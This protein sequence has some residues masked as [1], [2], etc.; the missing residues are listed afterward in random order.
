MKT[1][2]HQP[3]RDVLENQAIIYSLYFLDS[4]PGLFEQHRAGLNQFL[5]DYHLLRTATRRQQDLQLLL[6][7]MMY[8]E[9]NQDELQGILTQIPSHLLELNLAQQV[10]DK[11]AQRMGLRLPIDKPAELPPRDPSPISISHRLSPKQTSGSKKKTERFVPINTDLTAQTFLIHSKDEM[12]EAIRAINQGAKI[13]D[14]RLMASPVSAEDMQASLGLFKPDPKI[15]GAPLKPSPLSWLQNDPSLKAAFVQALRHNF[16]IISVHG[17]DSMGQHSESLASADVEK[18]L[19]RNLIISAVRKVFANPESSKQQK[20]ASLAKIDKMINSRDEDLDLQQLLAVRKSLTQGKRYT[21]LKPV[22]GPDDDLKNDVILHVRQLL[23]G[24]QTMKWRAECA[25]SLTEY[26]SQSA[27]SWYQF[28][29]QLATYTWDLDNINR[30]R[31]SIPDDCPYTLVRKLNHL[32]DFEMGTLQEQWSQPLKDAKTLL[33]QENVS[34]TEL[35]THLEA[36]QRVIKLYPQGGLWSAELHQVQEA[37]EQRVQAYSKSLEAD[38]RVYLMHQLKQYIASIDQHKKDGKTDFTHGF[39]DW[40]TSWT[41]SR[42]QNREANHFLAR[43]LLLGLESNKPLDQVFTSLSDLKS[44][45]LELMH[46]NDRPLLDHGMNSA[47][48]NEIIR[49]GIT[50]VN[51]NAESKKEDKPLADMPLHQ[52]VTLRD[53]KPTIFLCASKGLIEE[54]A[55]GEKAA[56]LAFYN[57]PTAVTRLSDAQGEWRTYEHHTGGFFPYHEKSLTLEQKQQIAQEAVEN[58]LHAKPKDQAIFI[59]CR[60]AD[61]AHRICAAFLLNEPNFDVDRLHFVP[62][63]GIKKPPSLGARQSG[64]NLHAIS[65]RNAYVEQHLPLYTKRDDPNQNPTRSL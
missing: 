60:H 63:N 39:Y 21:P 22:E 53:V 18:Y 24:G 2:H 17:L 6:R 52:G 35:L 32:L 50:W 15:H 10:K 59:Q 33:V 5:E 55:S 46:Q 47:R 42:A 58:Y 40:L 51:Q 65:I 8:Y 62:E 13:H 14:I 28:L 27:S 37:L 29:Q 45:R 12:I 56:V 34:L 26:S 48:L 36:I 4:N 25:D 61:D 43:E 57:Q 16:N 7:T 49:S 1:N 31:L 3:D 30:L 19:K 54:I 38:Q 23:K 9:Q 64:V 41:S 20:S 11:I 44:I